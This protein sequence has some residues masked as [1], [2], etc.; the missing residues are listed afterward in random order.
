MMNHFITKVFVEQPQLHGVCKFILI[1]KK[2]KIKLCKCLCF[3]FLITFIEM[4]LLLRLT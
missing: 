1:M 4:L 2:L 3:L